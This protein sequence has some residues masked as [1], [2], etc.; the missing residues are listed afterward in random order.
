MKLRPFG[1][2]TKRIIN[3]K[4]DK[5]NLEILHIQHTSCDPEPPIKVQIWRTETTFSKN[6][7]L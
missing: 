1:E 6:P 2:V 3:Y 4:H 7:P 5:D